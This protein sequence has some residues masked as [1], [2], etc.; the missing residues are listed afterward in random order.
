MEY[1]SGFGL[2]LVRFL[3]HLLAAGGLNMGR[4]VGAYPA[5]EQGQL[6]AEDAPQLT[7]M[8]KC[9]QLIGSITLRRRAWPKNSVRSWLF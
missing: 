8:L 3:R 4:T 7:N 2:R 5:P 9:P 1:A 6:G